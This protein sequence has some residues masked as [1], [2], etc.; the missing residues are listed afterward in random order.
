MSYPI[1][2][3]IEGWDVLVA[4][5]GTVAERKIK[6]VLEEKAEV[7]VIAPC[8]TSQID[9]WAEAGHVTWEKREARPEDV[10][11]ARLIFVA[12]DQAEV[13]KKIASAAAP[14]QLVNVAD[15]PALSTFHVPAMVKRGDFT[16]TVS[17]NGA[18]PS[19]A[20]HTKRALEEQFDDAYEDYVHFLAECREEIMRTVT[21][22]V[23][24]KNL[25]AQ[26]LKPEFLEWTRQGAWEE[27]DEAFA[28]ILQTCSP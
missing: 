25:F 20:K 13:N 12:T 15:N 3:A 2:L 27:R 9:M 24:R 5:G 8:V 18:S 26:L 22:P 28:Q 7:R 23:K 4:G 21:D 11:G 17:T 10:E 1:Q 16:V 6:H 19:L 14:F